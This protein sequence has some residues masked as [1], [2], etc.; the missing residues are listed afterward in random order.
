MKPIFR[1]FITP[2]LLFT[3][4][5]NFLSLV[6][7][8]AAI[9]EEMKTANVTPEAVFSASDLQNRE[10]SLQRAMD[11][12]NDLINNAINYFSIP[13]NALKSRLSIGIGENSSIKT[14]S[15]EGE[16][17]NY[18]PGDK[19]Y[20]DVLTN[21]IKIVDEA[22]SA[23]SR[24]DDI[25]PLKGLK[26]RLIAIVKKYVAAAT[27]VV[28]VAY[29]GLT[30]QKTSSFLSVKPTKDIEWH[31]DFQTGHLTY[32]VYGHA[33]E[34]NGPGSD[35][36]NISLNRLL[37]VIQGARYLL[38]QDPQNQ[39]KVEAFTQAYNS[40]KKFDTA[41]PGT[42]FGFGEYYYRPGNN[43]VDS[44]TVSAGQNTAEVIVTTTDPAYV[45]TILRPYSGSGTYKIAT[46]KIDFSKKQIVTE[47]VTASGVFDK[48]LSGDQL[49]E[50]LNLILNSLSQFLSR[51]H[52]EEDKSNLDEF[53][54]TLKKMQPES[55][56]ITSAVF[57]NGGSLTFTVEFT[58]DGA[59]ITGP[60]PGPYPSQIPDQVVKVGINFTTHI[61]TG[62]ADILPT[63]RG[64]NWTL[65]GMI[66]QLNAALSLNVTETN[67]EKQPSSEE[68]E[69]AKAKV[70]EFYQTL[71]KIQADTIHQPITSAVF[72]PDPFGSRLR[73]IIEFT[74]DGANIIS[75][76]P[77]IRREYEINFTTHLITRT[78]FFPESKEVL[79]PGDPSYD[80][81]LQ[82]L[83]DGVNAALGYQV[84][85][86]NN[87]K[88]VSSA[89]MDR[90]KAKATELYQTLKK[91][92]S[93]SKPVTV[94]DGGVIRIEIG[95]DKVRFKV[96]VQTYDFDFATGV[97][98]QFHSTLNTTQTF[99][100]G[101]EPDPQ[102][103]QYALGYEKVLGYLYNYADQLILSTT[104][105]DQVTK[106]QALKNQI[107]TTYSAL[108]FGYSLQAIP[109]GGFI[110]Q[111]DNKILF[112]VAAPYVSQ[113]YILDLKTGRL[114]YGFGGYG[115]W[116][117]PAATSY[118]SRLNT[119]ISTMQQA[120][121]QVADIL[122]GA[123]H[124]DS[125]A[126]YAER[127]EGLQVMIQHAQKFLP[128]A[129]SSLV[130][131]GRDTRIA[132]SDNFFK[133]VSIK[134]RRH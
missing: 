121:T 99:K 85:E 100:P 49:T 57:N 11:T 4:L 7:A 129:T 101:D 36:Y 6:P 119:F 74:V 31:L 35:A 94:I 18:N 28:E 14:T 65:E 12:K 110:L 70:N 130:V 108:H 107:K 39:D 111:T 103:T 41:K 71:K 113:T 63:D 115:S 76:G 13:T 29:A 126:Y 112:D 104:T 20:A 24:P 98:T 40:A 89:E 75:P 114:F 69:R 3:L 38:S 44:L 106:L 90:A 127:V 53:S 8:N 96:D 88:P 21:T 55:K 133:K 102:N 60:F 123:T 79:K 109:T 93:E 2:L 50:A 9:A 122:N 1:Q 86:T 25:G 46:F 82:L 47:N 131:G 77:G 54:Q 97:I 43:I 118:Q 68:M 73:E 62:G 67:N 81:Q 120:K 15:P 33:Y 78:Q 58:Q 37:T 27:G 134:K 10:N 124:P 52:N 23:G 64:Y 116:I 19:G 128:S 16:I 30:I 34:N 87:E 72:N 61:I 117:E 22:L 83:I 17:K 45:G 125:I 51:S 42:G 105:V 91:I 32:S 95:K 92:Q 5:I 66:K 26:E 80:N 56:P 132:D 48:N 84:E 59:L